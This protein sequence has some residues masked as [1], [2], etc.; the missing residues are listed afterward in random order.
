[1]CWESICSKD[2]PVAECMSSHRAA[3][4][5]GA[6]YLEASWTLRSIS[7]FLWPSSFSHQEVSFMVIEVNVSFSIDVG[8]VGVNG[9]VTTY[10]LILRIAHDALGGFSQPLWVF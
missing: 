10:N 5:K 7:P 6:H 2:S 3:G 1:M 9:K 4:P 8:T